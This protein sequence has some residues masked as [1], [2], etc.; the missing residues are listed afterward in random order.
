MASNNIR[1]CSYA[2]SG[3]SESTTVKWVNPRYACY[4]LESCQGQH[5]LDDCEYQRRERSGK[6][7][8]YYSSNAEYRRFLRDEINYKDLSTN[9]TGCTMVLLLIYKIENNTTWI[10]FVTKF[11][12]EKRHKYETESTRQSLLAFPSSNPCKKGEDHTEVALRALQTITDR[13]EILDN[14]QLRL[15]RFLFVDAISIYPFLVTSEQAKLLMRKYSQNEE[16]HSLHWFSLPEILNQ[17]PEWPNYLTKEAHGEAL[18]QIKHVQHP[19][20]QL[21][22]DI[23]GKIFT[24]WSVT[25]NVLMCIRNHVGFHEFLSSL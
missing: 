8:I 22:R 7:G 24:L 21:K 25:T 12:K 15:K 10:L 5:E 1:K 20:I 19:T 6:L 14:Y 17:L 13:Q 3:I 16:V 11:L 9:P 4:W 18:A 23:D 2:D